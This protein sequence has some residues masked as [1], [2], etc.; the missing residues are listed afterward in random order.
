MSA[1]HI[2]VDQYMN[3]LLVEKGLAQNTLEAYGKDL[4]VF[5]DFLQERKIDDLTKADTPDI[6]QHLIELRAQG[7]GARTRARHLVAIRGLF[8]FLEQEKIIKHNPAK[9]VDLPKTGMHLPDVISVEEIEQLLEAPN[10]MDILGARDRAMMELAYA[11]GLRVS[12]LIHVKVQDI[13]LDAGFVRVMGKGAKERIVPM[14][15]QAREKIKTYMDNDRPILL[16]GKPGEF[17]FVVRGGRPMTRQAFW[18]LL[19]KYALKAGIAKNITPHTLRHSFASH[20]LEG[21]ADLRVVQEML[22]HVDI[23]TTQIYT[24]VARERLIEIHERYHPRH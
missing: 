17:L 20:L 13:H 19:K 7:L 21:G 3:Y 11:S 22:G 5:T 8:S 14:G 9:L 6:L 4:G 18:K 12:E 23:S 1:S 16:K 10:E 24:H 15:R 2:L